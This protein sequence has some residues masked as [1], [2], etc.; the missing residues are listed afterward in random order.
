MM[1]QWNSGIMGS[2]L[3]LGEDNAMLDICSCHL[4]GLMKEFKWLVSF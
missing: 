4:Q 1:E 2:G 3:R